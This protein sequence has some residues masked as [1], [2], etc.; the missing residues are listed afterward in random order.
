MTREQ[1]QARHAELHRALDELLADYLRHHPEARPSTMRL[2]DLMQWSNEQQQLPTE[3][4]P[5]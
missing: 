5:R 3:L 4:E 1:H 2:V